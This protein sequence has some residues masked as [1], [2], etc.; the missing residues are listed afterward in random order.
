MNCYCDYEQPEFYNKRFVTARK[1]HSCCECRGAI[2]PGDSYEYVS[3]LWGGYFDTFKT[4]KH[5]AWIR[6]EF[7]EM[8]CFCWCHGG[9]FEAIQETMFEVDFPPGERFAYLR[10]I[11]KHKQLTRG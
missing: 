11:A 6:A 7:D 9:L 8:R 5:C 4:C 2:K 10:L 1:A 3:G